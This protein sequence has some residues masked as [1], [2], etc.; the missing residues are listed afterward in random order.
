MTSEPG[1]PEKV[2]VAWRRVDGEGHAIGMLKATDQGWSAHGYEVLARDG[3]VVACHFTVVLDPRWETREVQVDAIS[4][5][6]VT[7][8]VLRADTEHRWWRDGRRA[9]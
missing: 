7:R 9:A 2:L 1:G 3:E 8:L 4:A 6:G 5:L